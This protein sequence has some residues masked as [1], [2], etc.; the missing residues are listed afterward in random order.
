MST[1]RLYASDWVYV[2]Q[3]NVYVNDRTSQ[4]VSLKDSKDDT[5]HKYLFLKF[6]PVPE[7]YKYKKLEEA[8]YVNIYS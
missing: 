5:V 1:F 7:Q 8:A 2:T 4:K 3:S 6:E